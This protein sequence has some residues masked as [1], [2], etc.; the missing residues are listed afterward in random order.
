M[1]T[2]TKIAIGAGVVVT[3]GIAAT[4][5]FRKSNT[6]SSLRIDLDRIGVKEVIKEGGSK[7]LG[8]LLNLPIGIAYTFTFQVTNPT[9]EP[10]TLDSID[11]ALSIKD[12]SGN[13]KRIGGSVPTGNQ[14][15]TFKA[16]SREQLTHDV[17]IR[18]LN[19]LSLLPNFVSYA[20]GRLRGSKSTQQ[21]VA[22]IKVNSM[23]LTIPL[24]FKVNL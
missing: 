18:F 23:G 22:D 9:D 10:I 20:I 2:G 19:V 15:K 14:A 1:N 24:Q 8:A 13:L 4:H 21:A 17:E 11:T 16:N 6:A 3:A 7:L 12:K 5:F